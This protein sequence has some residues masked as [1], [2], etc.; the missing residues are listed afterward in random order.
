MSNAM[1]NLYRMCANN[2]IDL[3]NFGAAQ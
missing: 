1:G 3:G 2:N